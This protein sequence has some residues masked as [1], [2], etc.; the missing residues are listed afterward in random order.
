VWTNGEILGGPK[1][2]NYNLTERQGGLCTERCFSS[3]V[4][5]TQEK[6]STCLI[7]FKGVG[8]DFYSLWGGS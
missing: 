5:F 3:S 1:R 8:G 4:V 6:A 2:G 7:D